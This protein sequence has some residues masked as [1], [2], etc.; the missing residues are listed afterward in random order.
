MEGATLFNYLVASWTF[1][2]WVHAFAFLFGSLVQ[3]VLNKLR[4]SPP[5]GERFASGVALFDFGDDC[6][7]L[8]VLDDSL[9]SGSISLDE[10][11]SF[12]K[13]FGDF[14]DCFVHA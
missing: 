2:R 13:G 7:S 6:G 12:V 9:A 3:V 10:G 8:K 5:F 14:G 11:L 1:L 4:A